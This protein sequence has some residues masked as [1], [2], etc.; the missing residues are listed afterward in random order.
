MYYSACPFPSNSRRLCENNKK[1]SIEQLFFDNIIG[2]M[3]YHHQLQHPTFNYLSDTQQVKKV[4]MPNIFSHVI[5]NKN[6]FMGYF[7]DLSKV[8]MQ[9]NFFYFITGCHEYQAF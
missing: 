7:I 1:T 9:E 4:A 2:E 5:T 3:H 8:R 6:I